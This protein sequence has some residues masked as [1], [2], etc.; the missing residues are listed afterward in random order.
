MDY[1]QLTHY[2]AMLEVIARRLGHTVIDPIDY[3]PNHTYQD[4]VIGIDDRQHWL[5]LRAPMEFPVYGRLVH[6]MTIGGATVKVDEAALKRADS[7]IKALYI[8]AH[9]VKPIVVGSEPA[10]LTWGGSN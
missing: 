1:D 6:G 2:R 10:R 9:F 4:G 5:T 7:H 8:A 3:E